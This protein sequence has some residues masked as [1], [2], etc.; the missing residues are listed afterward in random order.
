[1]KNIS[2]KIWS[3]LYEYDGAL[4]SIEI[5]AETQLEAEDRIKSINTAECIGSVVPNDSASSNDLA[6]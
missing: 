6:A 4:Y 2:A 3:F 5:E 1:M